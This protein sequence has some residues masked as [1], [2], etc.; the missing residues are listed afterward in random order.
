M[1]SALV[2][3]TVSTLTTSQ[4]LGVSSKTFHYEYLVLS[5]YPM[6]IEN[7]PA[8]LRGC[9]EGPYKTLSG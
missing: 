4:L 6:L 1:I 3:V 8:I 7:S 2:S 5:V 9:R